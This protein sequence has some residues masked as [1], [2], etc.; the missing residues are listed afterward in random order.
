MKLCSD[1]AELTYAEVM[2]RVFEPVDDDV[3][4]PGDYFEACVALVADRVQRQIAA[5]PEAERHDWFIDRAMAM[6]GWC[7]RVKAPDA[8]AERIAVWLTRLLRRRPAPRKGR[9]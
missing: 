4:D 7:E 6:H 2:K 9:R 8:L 3:P 1:A 5:I